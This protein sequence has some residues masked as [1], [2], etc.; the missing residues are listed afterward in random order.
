MNLLSPSW[1][2]QQVSRA[3][4]SNLRSADESQQVIP[5]LKGVRDVVD[6]AAQLATTCNTDLIAAM[7]NFLIKSFAFMHIH[8]VVRCSSY[9]A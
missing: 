9:Y 7:D 1:L 6:N 4:L 8:E 3:Y 2:S 5:D